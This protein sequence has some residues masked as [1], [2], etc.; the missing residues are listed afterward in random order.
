MN[1]RCPIYRELKKRGEE[2]S[3][4]PLK[5]SR[6]FNTRL[7][8]VEERGKGDLAVGFVSEIGGKFCYKVVR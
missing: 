2:F 5:L 1:P 6:E 7:G 4:L 3:N 8:V